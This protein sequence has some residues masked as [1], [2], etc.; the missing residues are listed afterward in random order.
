M[1][2]LYLDGKQY[3]VKWHEFSDGALTCKI[4]EDT[5]VVVCD[6]IIFV[7]SP[8]TPVKQIKEEIALL[9]NA[10]NNNITYA[11][12]AKWILKIPYFPY[13]RADRK[14][15]VGN[16]IP[17][18]CLIGYLHGC[19]FDQIITN[20]IHNP[21]VLENTGLPIEN[22]SQL[23]CFIT[24]GG[25]HKDYDYV[26]IPD[27]GAFEKGMEIALYLEKPVLT[28]EKIR[29]VSTGKILSVE[30]TSDIPENASV[31]IVDDIFDGGGTFLPIAEELKAQGCTV[32][33]Y[34]THMIGSRG[35][36]LFKGLVDNIICYQTVGTYVNQTDI[37]NYNLE[38]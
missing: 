19:N 28:F 12:H 6:E 1:I 16:G 33:L 21:D 25:I 14:F 2:D 10:I 18:D 34:V 23:K 8:R 29:D 31:I 32:D 35:L 37:L 22:I 11:S 24:A 13:A 15:E 36:D 20:D 27:K 5:P 17:L 30:P 3:P 4:S 7:V 26:V 9:Y 38:N